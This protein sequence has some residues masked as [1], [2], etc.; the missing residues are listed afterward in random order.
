MVSFQYFVA[1][2]LDGFIATAGDNL[3]WLLQFDGFE[4]GQDSYDAFIADVG[5]I[6]MGGETYACLRRRPRQG[7]RHRRVAREH[8]P[9]TW[10]Y[11]GTPSW[12]FTRHEHAAPRARM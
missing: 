5:C 11:P 4:G 2:S 6:V 9:D 10:P 8:E 7:R 1:S 3:A 12:V